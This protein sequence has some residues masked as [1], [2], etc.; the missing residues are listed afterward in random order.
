[1]T[2]QRVP[3]C[4]ELRSSLHVGFLPN[5]AGT[6]VARTRC[7]VPGKNLWGGVTAQ[8]TPRL[9]SNPTAGDYR[10]VGDALQTQAVFSY[11]YLSDGARLF[12]PD[13]AGAG[14]RWGGLSDRAFRAQVTASRTSTRIAPTGGAQD[15]MLHEIEF[16]RHRVGSPGEPGPLVLLLGAAWV[17]QD[18]TIA[19]YPVQVQE[20]SV[21]V[22]GTDLFEG[23]TLGGERNYGFGRVRRVGTT[24]WA[25]TMV[26][27]LWPDQPD[28][29]WTLDE[30]RPILAHLAYQDGLAFRGQVEIVAGREYRRDRAGAL[31]RE[32][33]QQITTEGYCFAPGTRLRSAVTVRLDYWGRLLAWVQPADA[34][35]D[36][37]RHDAG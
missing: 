34:D 32:P 5:G 7:Y 27:E 9:I 37:D 35:T 8:L 14:L 2:W 24:D 28:V 11:C 10:V 33:G 22:D 25:R 18:A 29:A 1:M 12:T 36:T 13:Y 4:F 26:G 16:V 30:G 3:V 6:V 17:R 15:A 31:F 23:A 20:E 21:T 19:G